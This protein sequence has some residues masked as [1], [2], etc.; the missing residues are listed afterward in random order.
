MSRYEIKGSFFIPPII[1]RLSRRVPKTPP[2]RRALL[3]GK[4]GG[5]TPHKVLVSQ[6]GKFLQISQ[7]TVP[8][9]R[10]PN[11]TKVS[12]GHPWI[13][14]PLPVLLAD[15]ALRGVMSLISSG[16]K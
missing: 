11:G 6:F 8:I 10:I 1:H 4:G 14:P 12:L 2:T 5:R 13:Y 9:Q 16:S 3:H 15:V 7:V